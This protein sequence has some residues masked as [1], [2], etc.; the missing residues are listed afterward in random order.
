MNHSAHA[1]TRSACDEIC[2]CVIRRCSAVP[3]SGGQE[4]RFGCEFGSFFSCADGATPGDLLKGGIYSEI[5]IA[6]KGG[7]WR[8][9]S[10]AM[11]G[12]ALGLS[13]EQAEAAAE[14][15]DVYGQGVDALRGMAASRV[16]GAVGKAGAGVER[17]AQRVA[18]GS[19][20]RSSTHPATSCEAAPSTVHVYL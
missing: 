1:D 6:L 10:M 16:G 9:A 5:A 18:R 19:R 2:A 15:V 13:K 4:A 20:A 3:G 11:L 8:E 14:G 12:M 17:F 7:P